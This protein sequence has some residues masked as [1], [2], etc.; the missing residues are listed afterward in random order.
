MEK[1]KCAIEDSAIG[2]ITNID[3]SEVCI[4]GMELESVIATT[5]TL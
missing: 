2:L 4:V 1:F 3:G 5:L